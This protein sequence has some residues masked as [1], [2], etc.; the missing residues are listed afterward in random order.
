MLGAALALFVV[1][2][3]ADAAAGLA[4]SPA[5]SSSLDEE[6]KKKADEDHVDDNADDKAPKTDDKDDHADRKTS[7]DDDE[8]LKD[9]G[10]DDAKAAKKPVDEPSDP[11]DEALKTDGKDDHA[12][13]KGD[14]KSPKDDGKDDAKAAKKDGEEPADSDGKQKQDDKDK[15]GD[16]GVDYTTTPAPADDSEMTILHHIASQIQEQVDS[17]KHQFVPAGAALAFGLL[18]LFNGKGMFHLL[19]LAA[20]FVLFFVFAMSEVSAA[21]GVGR[22]SLI[23][24]VVGLEAGLLGAFVAKRGIDGVVA[25]VGMAVGALLAMLSREELIHLGMSSLEDNRGLIVAMYSV[26]VLVFAWVF[27]ASKHLRAVAL[28]S[29][30]AGGLLVSSA[31][32]WAVTVIAIRSNWIASALPAATPKAGTWL[33]FFL[34]LVHPDAN[35]VGVFAHSRYN[36]M[37]HGAIWRTDRVVGLV[38]AAILFIVGFRVQSRILRSSLAADARECDVLREAL[39]SEA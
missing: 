36:A 8:S 20:A 30:I 39:L 5:V 10:K 9:A 12:D 33:D 34:L 23:S 24:H 19:L 35:D 1:G 17:G 31:V 32:S 3:G 16:D 7:E 6:P 15:S 25:A 38:L 37:V 29:S 22:H 4:A 13:G 14:N 26:F 11:D 27:A 21:L 18:M 2:V 28:F